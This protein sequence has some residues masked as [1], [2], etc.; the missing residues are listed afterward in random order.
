MSLIYNND[1]KDF[2]LS[3][4]K[5]NERIGRTNAFEHRDIKFK[6]YETESIKDFENDVNDGDI[7]RIH[8]WYVR[9]TTVEVNIGDTVVIGQVSA[10][11][12]SPYE[13]RNNE[14]IVNINFEILQNA[15]GNVDVSHQ[16]NRSL[17]VEMSRLLERNILRSSM[18]DVE[19]LCIRS[20]E[21]V[22]KIDINLLL[23]RYA[24]N[25]IDTAN[26][27][28]L[29]LLK[30]FRRP[31]IEVKEDVNNGYANITLMKDCDMIPLSILH[32]P[33][34]C[35]FNF[36]NDA[37]QYVVDA[38]E[39]EEVFS[40][41]RMMI[42]INEHLEICCMRIQGEGN[43]SQE[44]LNHCIRIAIK[45]C[46]C[47]RKRL[48]DNVDE[49]MKKNLPD[50]KVKRFKVSKFNVEKEKDFES[51]IENEKKLIEETEKK[52]KE[53]SHDKTM[54]NDDDDDDEGEILLKTLTL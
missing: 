39:M 35:T 27:C 21:Q 32:L 24:G 13:S 23:Y 28:C 4:L 33:I 10:R 43:I 9:G 6:F 30:T 45:H 52:M 51:F 42:S 44:K 18:I 38:N 36:F 49:F 19:S 5:I 20:N 1:N 54:T 12:Q 15:F 47:L 2:I 17:S 7:E 40:S 29:A 34:F 48:L 37:Q 31:E 11:I 41:S 53:E 26:L 46:K 14:G 25:I 16:A 50:Q 22:W 3:A 8:N